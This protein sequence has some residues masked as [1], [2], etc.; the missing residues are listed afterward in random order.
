MISVLIIGKGP[1]GISAA[2]YAKRTGLDV[3]II[4]KDYGAL[5][6][7]DLVENYYGFIQ[8]I[9]GTDLIEN[10]IRQAE[11]LGITVMN[12]EVVSI[13]YNEDY[14]VKTDRNEYTAKSVIFATGS[15]RQVPNI[16]GIREFEGKGISYCAVCDSFFYR[17]KNVA[18]LGCCDY[19][20]NEARELLN[21]AASV[22]IL[23]NGM[24]PQ[25]TIPSDAQIIRQKV[26]AISGNDHVE[27]VLFEDGTSLDT[28]GLFV[29]Y[30]V[31]GSSDFARKLGIAM[32]NNKIIVDQ[33]MATN[34]PGLFAAGDCVGGIYQIAKAVNDG[35]VAGMSASRYVRKLSVI[36]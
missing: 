15:P 14:I 4:G 3:T 6:K 9:K 21:V 10:G 31:A 32:Q 1:A 28:N 8:P 34:L 23:T 18:V 17:Q 7:A 33:A 35:S 16:K 19:A 26:A 25:G 11:R 30:G 27:K 29:A 12:E 5:Q 36:K 2:I 22:T 13:T 24:E 20:M